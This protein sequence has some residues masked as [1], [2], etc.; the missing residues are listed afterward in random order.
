ML[1]AS[2]SNGSYTA[3][4]Y[5]PLSLISNTN[6]TYELSNNQIS[7]NKAGITD[8]KTNITF[9]A[10]S[11]ATI[12]AQLYANGLVISNAFASVTSVADNTYTLSISYPIQIKR[13]CNNQTVQLGVQ[14]SQDCTLTGGYV[15]AEYRQ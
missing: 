11:A 2:I 9:V 13:A 3:G 10:T 1:K 14:L 4:T 7:V 12:I 15:A 5:L 8:I 6:K